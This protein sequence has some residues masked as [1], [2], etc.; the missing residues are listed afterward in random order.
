MLWLGDRASPFSCFVVPPWGMTALS[1]ITENRKIETRK[2][3]IF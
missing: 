1:H 2:S 3:L